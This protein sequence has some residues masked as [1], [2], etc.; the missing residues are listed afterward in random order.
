MILPIAVALRNREVK[1]HAGNF[2][3]HPRIV[4]SVSKESLTSFD[5]HFKAIWRPHDHLT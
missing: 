1:G 4:T 3:D 5:P 2:P